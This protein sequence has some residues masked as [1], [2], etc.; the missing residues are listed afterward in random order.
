MKQALFFLLCIF[1]LVATAQKPQIKWGEEFNLR[2]GSTDLEAIY[3]DKS[4]VYLQEGHFA[5]KSYFV[6]GA[7]LRESGTLV[8]LD[9]NLSEVYRNDFNKELKGKE[10]VQF[11]P[12]QE[13][14]FLLAS[15][16]IK[17]EKMLNIYGVEINKNTGEISGDWISLTS[18]QKEEKADDINFKFI[19]SADSSRMILVSSVEGKERN[20]YRIQEFDKT[21]KSAARAINISNEFDPKTFQLE[22]VLYTSNKKIFLVGRR[23]EYQEGK[24]KKD[25]FLEFARYNIRMYNEQGKQQTEI[26]T[27]INGKWITSTK[28]VQEKNKDIVLLAFYNDSR[29]SKTIDGMLVQRI[30]P[31]SGQVVATSEKQI[32]NSLLSADIDQPDDTDADE[33]ESKAERKERERLSKMKDE[34][35]AFSKYM[36]FRNVFYTAD[37][38]LVILAE[39]YHHYTY[40][41][42]RYT[43]GSHGSPGDWR[44]TL[45]SVYEC[46]D[47]LMCKIDAGGN[48]S[49]L[50][51]L[52]KA[53]KEIIA[54]GITSGYIA[55]SFF[56]FTNRPFYAGFGAMQTKNTVRIIFNDH[57]KNADI[58]QAGQKA[59]T[60]N[61]YGTSNC[62]LISVDEA[63]GKCTRSV[64]YS[65]ADVPTSMPRL[66]SVLDEN[67][68]IV[69]K[70]DRLFGKSKLAVARLVIN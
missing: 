9:N 26:N 4:G 42:Q 33:K 68:Y 14:L 11:F 38:G 63:T 35:E 41:S 40:A 31:N 66:G 6:I 70:E 48:I 59:K 61:R 18:L 12:L 21:L 56:E 28:L 3:A 37:N 15:E 67:M 65:N 57:L 13:K 45:Y 69:G 20:E 10:F 16:Y 43:P 19:M 25:K 52:P 46:G 24:K 54:E 60:I 51:V 32:N 1:T 8:K 55:P 62:Y 7:T 58:T 47:I 50:Q 53:Q 22:D 27:E 5:V 30:D 64:L 44:T 34:G 2:R 49:W 39:K 36:Q 17:R 23:Y 29:K